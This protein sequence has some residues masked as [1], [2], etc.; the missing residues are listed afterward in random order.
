MV[1]K[2]FPVN[3]NFL[4]IRTH[5]E[6][7]GKVFDAVCKALEVPYLWVAEVEPVGHLDGRHQAEVGVQDSQVEE[8]RVGS[9]GV[10]FF[11]DDLPQDQQV[12]GRTHQQLEYLHP[13]VEEEAVG[14]WSARLKIVPKQGAGQRRGV[15]VGFGG[16]VQHDYFGCI[17]FHMTKESERDV[18]HSGQCCNRVDIFTL[19][20]VVE[21]HCEN[22]KEEAQGRYIFLVS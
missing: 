2:R 6:K 14:R 1:T 3:Q 12:A 16:G 17:F 19:M 20:N 13:V 10:A 22:G 18:N 7:C 5:Q 4:S 21:H 15:G 11:A 8:E 9:G